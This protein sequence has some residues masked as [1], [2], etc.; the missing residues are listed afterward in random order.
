MGETSRP[1]FSRLSRHTLLQPW[2]SAEGDQAL[3]Q[4]HEWRFS[5]R[6]A[7]KS[8]DCSLLLPCGS[9]RYLQALNHQLFV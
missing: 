9:L 7:A 4:S 6:P 5:N 1:Q 3:R 8:P 2:P